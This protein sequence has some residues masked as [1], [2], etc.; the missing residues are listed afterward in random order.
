MRALSTKY[1][2]NPSV[3]SRPWDIDRDGFVLSEGSGILC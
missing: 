1:N 3:A 2:D